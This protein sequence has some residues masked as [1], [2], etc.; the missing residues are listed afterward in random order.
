MHVSPLNTTVW[1]HDF[2]NPQSGNFEATLKSFNQKG[3]I[4]FG[5]SETVQSWIGLVIFDACSDWNRVLRFISESRRQKNDRIISISIDPE[6]IVS[7]KKWELLCAGSNDV[8]EW[9]HQTDPE[10]S[11]LARINRWITIERI[12]KSDRVQKNLIGQSQIWL[13]FLRQCI[14]VASYTQASV[15][16]MGE[17]G[18]GKELVARLIHTLDTRPQKSKLVLVD[19]TTIVP[20]LS[21][22]E[23]FGHEKGA[24][25]NAISRREGAF[26]LA[27]RGTLFLDEVGE[28]PLNLQSELLRVIQE[29]AYKRVGSNTWQQ[30]DFRLVCATNRDIISE[31]EA[32]HFRHDLYYRLSSWICKMPALHQR[33]EDIPLLAHYFLNKTLN[34]DREINIEPEVI[35][36][37]MNRDYPGN[38]RELE[39]LVNRIAYRHVGNGSVTIGDIPES[40]RPPI[41]S[42]NKSLQNGDFEHIIHAALAQGISL[43]GIKKLASEMAMDVT[44]SEYGGNLQ[45]AARKL[46]VTDR[47]LQLYLA[48]KNSNTS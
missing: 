45:I 20:E 42:I 35:R 29:G 16:I 37:L 32:G 34:L 44:I 39:Q 46:G 1:Y 43:K 7:S 25:T 3:H 18:T 31:V 19:C 28:L 26:A 9:H 10:T 33:R 21:G 23:F 15:L 17:S 47:T 8:I 14:E 27:D 41:E 48:S 5:K 12:L 30:T 2:S 4:S 6:G 40:D 11:I 24:F 22:S 13:N 38:V 36:F